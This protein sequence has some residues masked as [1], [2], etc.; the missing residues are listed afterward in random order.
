MIA[1]TRFQRR[2]LRNLLPRLGNLG[3]AAEHQ[4]G[5]HQRAGP[6]AAFGKAAIDQQ[7]IDANFGGLLELFIVSVLFGGLSWARPHSIGKR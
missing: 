1:P 5:Q 3:L 7:L 2:I 6:A 4:S